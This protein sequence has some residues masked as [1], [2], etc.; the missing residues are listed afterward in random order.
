[1][2]HIK[3]SPWAGVL[4]AGFLAACGGGGGGNAS[5]PVD[6]TTVFQLK[7]AWDN[8]ARDTATRSFSVSGTHTGGALSGTGTLT[9]GGL[10]GTVFEGLAAQQKTTTVLATLTRTYLGA[11]STMTLQVASSSY[12]DGNY[13]PLGSASSDE[14][15]VV[16]GS[17]SIPQTARIG[18][19]GTAYSENRYAD[20]AKS[21]L[22]GTTTYSYSLQADTASTAIARIVGV[23]KDSGGATTGTQTLLY[24]IT[25]AGAATPTIETIEGSTGVM[26]FTFD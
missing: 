25:P 1:M 15:T 14:Y 5:P 24:R 17:V 19:S 9:Q 22:L 11:S 26:V 16:D 7:T 2:A 8:M 21:S 23:E 3:I 20:S 4:L 13:L 6:S 12:Y 10:F 18:D